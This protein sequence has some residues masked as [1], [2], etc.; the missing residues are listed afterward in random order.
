LLYNAD[1]SELPTTKAEHIKIIYS[2]TAIFLTWKGLKYNYS[3]WAN[4][5]TLFCNRFFM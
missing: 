1:D 3:K 5:L 4:S 2:F